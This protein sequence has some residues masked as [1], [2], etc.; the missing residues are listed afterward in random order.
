[1]S[2]GDK[3][4]GSMSSDYFWRR[5]WF[6]EDGRYDP[7]GKPKDNNY[8][9]T[10]T[11]VR[12]AKA[13]NRIFS[14]Q[15]CS[16][17]P[18]G[19]WV[20][21]DA[22]L[23]SPWQ[24]N[25]ELKL[26]GRLSEKVRGHNFD[27]GNM[28]GEGRETLGSVLGTMGA[29]ANAVK[30]VRAGNVQGAIKALAN[31]PAGKL[32]R[33]G[34]TT[35]H[36]GKRLDTRDLADN[37]LGLEY[38]WKPLLSDVFESAKAFEALTSGPRTK[39]YRVKLKRSIEGNMSASPGLYTCP[40]SRRVTAYLKFVVE[41]DIDGPR[42]LGLSDPLGVAWEVMPYSF[43]ADWFLPIGDY[44]DA[45]SLI[46]F[47]KGRWVRSL[48]DISESHFGEAISEYYSCPGNLFDFKLVRFTR[49]HGVNGTN[50][51]VPPPSFNNPWKALQAGNRIQNAAALIRG[52]F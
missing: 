51:Y 26:L 40:G 31:A 15:K 8:T 52:L 47:L 11:S 32:G 37:W 28:I 45:L 16:D 27:L 24:P 36:K 2:T 30:S 13:P 19:Y 23:P 41:E 49:T 42:S 34:Q 39:T 22:L 35:L 3:T 9:V 29:I 21:G 43:I 46:P 4:V 44:L 1:M 38:A 50:Y 17:A 18:M 7:A 12:Q 20:R 6:G 48:K 14:A 5:V 25:D 33:P 10:L